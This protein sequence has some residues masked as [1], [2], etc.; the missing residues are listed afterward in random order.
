MSE[1]ARLT[2]PPPERPSGL[3]CNT[4]LLLPV[5][6]ITAVRTPIGLVVAALLVGHAMPARA[7]AGLAVSPSRASGATVAKVIVGTTARAMPGA[8]AALWHVRTATTWGDGPQQLLVLARA[9]GPVGREWLKVLLP[10]RPNGAT[11]WIRADH[12]LTSHTPFWVQVSLANRSISVYRSGSLVRRFGAVIGASATP[13]PRG[14][15][16]IYD[17]IA[18]PDPRGFLGPWALHL[19]A[20]SEVLDDYGGGPGRVAIH[21]RNGASLQDPLG[22][23]RSHGCIRVDDAQV[24]WMSRTLPRGTP[25]S[26]IGWDGDS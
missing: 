4:Y 26:V 8:G 23:A 9:R 15:H 7:A 21:G 10:L 1:P 2:P 6:H 13:T 14:L 16:A 24:R 11:G 5:R 20:F 22:T 19:T 18:Q 17:P 12:V 3:L 25:V